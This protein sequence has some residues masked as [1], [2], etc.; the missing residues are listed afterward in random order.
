MFPNADPK[1]L[2]EIEAQMVN[3][4]PLSLGFEPEAAKVIIP[5]GKLPGG[6]RKVTLRTGEVEWAVNDLDFAGYIEDGKLISNSAFWS[7]RRTC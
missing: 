2:R 3:R 7:G 5:P 6:L 1:Y 4:G